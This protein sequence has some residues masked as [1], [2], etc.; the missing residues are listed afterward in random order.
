MRAKKMDLELFLGFFADV[1][2][3][4]HVDYWTPSVSKNLRTWLQKNDPLKPKRRHQKAYA[5]TS[6]KH[7][8]RHVQNDRR[9]E[10]GVKDLEVQEPEWNGLPDISLLL[11]AIWRTRAAVSKS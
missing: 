1:V 7:F 2:G 5:P 4:D 8:S 11:R 10:T 6:L 9:F 3:S